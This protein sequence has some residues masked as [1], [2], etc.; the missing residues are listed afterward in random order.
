MGSVYLLLVRYVPSHVENFP[1]FFFVAD[2]K[3]DTTWTLPRPN[4]AQS[5]IVSRELVHFT[6]SQQGVILTE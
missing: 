3:P 2:H 6:L 4:G 1:T 5:E